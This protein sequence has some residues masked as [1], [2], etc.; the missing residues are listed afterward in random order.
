MAGWQTIK[1]NFDIFDPLKPPLETTLTVL[2]TIEAILEALLALIKPFM[3]DLLNPLKAII[4]ALLA[5]IRAIINQIRAT[6][7]SILLVH[8]DFSNPDISGIFYSVAGAYPGFESK[9]IA[10]FYDTSDIFRPQYPPG[11]S[12][13]M[14]I[15]YLGADSPGDLMGLLFALLDLIQH[16]I[17]IGGI[18][19]PVDLKVRPVR[20]GSSAVSQFRDLFGPGLEKALEVEWRMPQMPAGTDVAGFANQFV[21]FFNQFR[22][23]NFIVER[24][25]PFPQEEGET[26]RDP[27]GETVRMEVNSLTM[28]KIAES[29]VEKYKFP[30]VNSKV[31]V[32]EEDGSVHRIFSNKRVIQYGSDGVANEGN[33]EGNVNSA[34][35]ETVTALVTGVGTGIYKFLDNDENLVAGR[36]YYYR[37]RGFFGNASKY[38]AMTTPD[39]VRA[40][41]KQ[42]DSAEGETGGGDGGFLKLNGNLPVLKWGPSFNLGKPS[43]VVKGFVPKPGADDEAFNVYKD[44]YKAIRAGL[45]LNF[46]LPPANENDSQRRI[47]QKTG[48]GTLGMLGG[49]IGLL[50]ATYDDSDELKDN[51][52]FNATARRLANSVASVIFSQPSL[53]EIL[54]Q[55]WINGVQETVEQVLGEDENGNKIVVMSS[56]WKFIGIIGGITSSTNEKIDAYL[57]KEDSYTDLNAFDGPLPIFGVQLPSG[58]SGG[59]NISS[60]GVQA[61]LDL[62]TFIRTATS[63]VSQQIGYMSWYSVTVGDLFPALVPFLEDFLQW[64]EALLNAIN[65]ALQELIDI[66][67]TLLQKVRALIQLVEMIL[68]ILDLLNITFQV[69]V[70]A[71]ASS[72]GSTDTLVQELVASEDKPGDSPYGLHSGM[73]MTFGGPG[74]GFITALEVLAFILTLGEVG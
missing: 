69:S 18:P 9:V 67:E 46:E 68:A 27:R 74:Q 43:R 37:I 16:P 22:F 42:G 60:I 11:M 31:V 57:A 24:N 72:N 50:K 64:L 58:E 54:G 33:P 38:L 49:Q 62:A 14:L 56:T 17:D 30:A 21:A 36:T 45:L 25:G 7:F 10:K 29:T 23:P 32:R 51:L 41:R 20:E 61:R 59:S 65:S 55:Q 52:G 2:E 28:G 8:P 63:L 40:E 71:T 19:A 34:T 1:F 70:L 47:E 48:W 26:P 13:A 53:V 35:A 15:L 3:L 39:A 6:G 44:V 5:A 12:V 4:A 73:V 66:I